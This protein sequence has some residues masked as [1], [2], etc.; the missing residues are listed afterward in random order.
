MIAIFGGSFDPPHKGHLGVVLSFCE[1]YPDSKLILV[2][3]YLSPF[4]KEKGASSGH[5]LKML[6]LLIQENQL[7]RV[8]ISDIEINQEKLSYTIDTIYEYKKKH[9]DLGLIIGADNLENFSSWK[10]YEK[11]LEQVPLIV[12]QREGFT[13]QIP[14]ELD[15]FR[16]RIKIHKNKKVLASSTEFKNGNK[17]VLT[18][19][20][21]DYILE[22]NLYNISEE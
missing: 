12:F 10:D 17:E 6:E 14:E 8:S 4:K 13:I 15:K 16:T 1:S 11:I 7:D 9:P 5:I 19:K 21:Q 20:V 22:N 18:K 3:A 2:P